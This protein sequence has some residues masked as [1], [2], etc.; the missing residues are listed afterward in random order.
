MIQYLPGV[1]TI[2]ATHVHRLVV[3]RIGKVFSQFGKG[4]QRFLKGLDVVGLIAEFS[5]EE[6]GGVVS[7]S[8]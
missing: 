4:P 3:G 6:I 8:G 2:I 7:K 1:A 5:Y